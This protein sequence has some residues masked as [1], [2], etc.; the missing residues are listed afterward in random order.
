MV[1]GEAAHFVFVFFQNVL[2]WCVRDLE[3]HCPRGFAADLYSVTV[4]EV[5]NTYSSWRPI[6][7]V[8]FPAEGNN[9]IMISNFLSISFVFFVFHPLVVAIIVAVSLSVVV[10]RDRCVR[11]HVG[12]YRAYGT[13]VS[14]YVDV[15]SLFSQC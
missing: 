3:R 12:H 8:G 2:I 15:I 4:H 6:G 14:L 9:V 7:F 11:Y 1:V 13:S 5:G 10:N